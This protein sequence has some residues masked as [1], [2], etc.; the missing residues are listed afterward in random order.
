MTDVMHLQTN[1]KEFARDE[2][3]IVY[4]NTVKSVP[5]LNL[6]IPTYCQGQCKRT[7]TMVLALKSPTANKPQQAGL[8]FV[9]DDFVLKNTLDPQ[10]SSFKIQAH[11]MSRIA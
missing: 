11:S 6:F 5:L 10:I 1:T 8:D 4:I 7:M 9:Q 2:G 3:I